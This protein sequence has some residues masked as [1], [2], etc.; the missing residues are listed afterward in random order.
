MIFFSENSLNN[1]NNMNNVDNYSFMS[2]PNF[3]E[4]NSECDYPKKIIFDKYRTD[5]VLPL[6]N[7]MDY[8]AAV[9]SRLLDDR[10]L[11]KIDEI[12]K[13]EEFNNMN[14]FKEK[15]KPIENINLT[16]PTE[17]NNNNQKDKFKKPLGRLSKKN[18]PY[19]YIGKHSSKTP[20]NFSNK[21]IRFCMKSVY[22]SLQ[23]EIK[24]YAKTKKI[25]IRRLHVPTIKKYLTK[26][27]S[28][29]CLLL[30]T[31]VKTLFIDMMPKR[32]KKEIENDREKYCHN[33]LIL[34]KILKIEED[35]IKAKVKT[36]NIKF[37]A[38]FNIYL[39]A[40][41][42]NEKNLTINGEEFQLNE[43]FDTLNDFY[44]EEKSSYTEKEKMECEK[45]VYKIINKTIQFR[46][47]KF[48]IK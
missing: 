11:N 30:E 6:L 26:G 12:D 2:N 46:K 44:K 17:D 27:N 9:N 16:V 38:Q 41:L 23:K 34:N 1:E 43:E 40:F 15:K 47:K 21:I 13:S 35:D 20:D 24:L 29:K 31:A 48:K 4:D 18:Y 33:K 7:V 37:N 22:K 25:R 45:Y 19:L 36:L 42:K 10:F 32:V 5:K 39:K 3:D 8:F 14:H 28:E